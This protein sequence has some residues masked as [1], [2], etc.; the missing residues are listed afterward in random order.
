MKERDYIKEAEQNV[1]NDSKYCQDV[2]HI[3][4]ALRN[5]A[6][7]YMDGRGDRPNYEKA[8]EGLNMFRDAVYHR[9]VENIS[10]CFIFTG[11]GGEEALKFS[12]ERFEEQ[13]GDD[14]FCV[15]HFLTKGG[16][17]P[18]S[19]KTQDEKDFREQAKN[20]IN[21]TDKVES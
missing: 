3:I 10:K 9:F 19:W 17:L 16:Y 13:F 2:L 6:Y 8:M 14:R 11:V 20:K 4:E 21:L 18:S 1:L 7:N 15:M 12:R 5:F